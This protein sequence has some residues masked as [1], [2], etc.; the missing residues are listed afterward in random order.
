M[1]RDPSV[2]CCIRRAGSQRSACVFEDHPRFAQTSWVPSRNCCRISSPACPIRGVQRIGD[3][4]T[5]A[6]RW[7]SPSRFCQSTLSYGRAQEAA[8]TAAD[9]D[10]AGVVEVRNTAALPPDASIGLDQCDRTRAF[11]RRPIPISCFGCCSIWCAKRAQKALEGR[12]HSDAAAC[13]FAI[14]AARRLGR[15]HRGSP[16]PAPAC[17][18]KAASNL[19]EA[20]QTS[21]RPGGSGLGSRI[22]A[23]LVRAHGRRHP[24]GG[25][26][27]RR[28]LPHHLRTGRGTRERAQRTRAGIKAS[29]A[30]P[31]SSSFRASRSDE[32]GTRGICTRSGFRAHARPG[33]TEGAGCH[34]RTCQ[35]RPDAGSYGALSRPLTVCRMHAASAGLRSRMPA[36]TRA[37]AQLDKH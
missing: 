37:V 35:A 11:D 34:L 24:S 2:R 1:Q 27:H 3:V 6:A 29:P 33:M 25:R 20:F 4:E 26:H 9:P 28:D 5:D 12:P 7:S 14:T 8:P 32:P 31:F 10:R 13:R 21:G 18:P 22:A 15:H 36:E 30:P 19:F 16:I 17:P 23:E